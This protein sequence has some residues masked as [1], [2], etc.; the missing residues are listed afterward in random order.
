ML[1]PTY[2]KTSHN[3]TQQYCAP[4]CPHSPIQQTHPLLHLNQC[5]NPQ[6]QAPRDHMPWL[7]PQ[8]HIHG[9]THIGHLLH[10]KGGGNNHSQTRITSSPSI[11]IQFIKFTY[12]HD[13]FPT[14]TFR[15]KHNKYNLLI[16]NSHLFGRKWTPSPPS[17][18][19]KGSHSW[20]FPTSMKTFKIFPNES[21]F[22]WTHTS[23][24]NKTP[25][26]LNKRKLENKQASTS[27][28]NPS[29]LPLKYMFVHMCENLYHLP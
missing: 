29:P 7:A 19:V 23:H 22:L 18:S 15:E 8:M 24:L 4:N 26:I 12:C 5:W 9:Q 2:K 20:T 21:C 14:S 1:K 10:S 28:W 11:I 13:R 17:P 27:I 25:Y 3:H 16:Q 6:S